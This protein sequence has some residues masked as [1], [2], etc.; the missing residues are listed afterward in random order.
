VAGHARG[1]GM[2]NLGY[3]QVGAVG[4]ALTPTNFAAACRVNVVGCLA[5][6]AAVQYN[7]TP[8]QRD[9]QFFCSELVARAFELAGVPLLE[10][11][12]SFA[13]PREIF[14]CKTLRCVGRII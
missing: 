8:S 1:L 11:E 4:S 10:E 5:V 3:D 13:N 7:A 12:A 14:E 2:R 6:G 9:L